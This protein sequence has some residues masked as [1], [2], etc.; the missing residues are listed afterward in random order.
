MSCYTG[1]CRYCPRPC[2][3]LSCVWKTNDTGKWI[4]LKQEFLDCEITSKMFR[5]KKTEDGSWDFEEFDDGEQGYR[6][7]FMGLDITWLMEGWYEC[8]KMRRS[9]KRKM[10]KLV[11][12]RLRRLRRIYK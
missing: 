3:N 7:N 6:V 2:S 1:K 12:K 11:E 9:K 8:R 10:R 4:T 5:A